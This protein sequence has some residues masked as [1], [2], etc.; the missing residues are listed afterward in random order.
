M[1]GIIMATIHRSV[2]YRFIMATIHRSVIDCIIMVTLYSTNNMNRSRGSYSCRIQLQVVSNVQ[3]TLI[4]KTYPLNNV[5]NGNILATTKVKLN[6][7][8]EGKMQF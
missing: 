7:T 1:Y 3:A 4:N 8:I 5:G 2:I 6:K